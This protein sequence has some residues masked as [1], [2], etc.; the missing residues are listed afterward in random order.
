[1]NTATLE[2]ACVQVQYVNQPKGNAVSGSIKDANGDYYGVHKSALNRFQ[3]GGEYEFDFSTN[4]AFR[5]I[6]VKTIQ[7]IATARP[8][9]RAQAQHQQQD[10]KRSDPVDPP[11]GNGN[12]GNYY[13]PTSPADKKSMFRCA[14]VGAF[15]KAGMLRI[16]RNEIANA[17]VEIDAGYDMAMK[18]LGQEDAAG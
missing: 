1:M 13:R 3:E 17:I 4:G 16:D 11:R 2:H 18:E 15:I 7:P 12:G 10:V 6:D 5:N 8:Q 9:P 14:Q